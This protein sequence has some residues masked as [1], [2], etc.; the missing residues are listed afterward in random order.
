MGELENCGSTGFIPVNR[1][2]PTP[3]SDR[4]YDNCSKP[5]GV[6]AKKRKSAGKF[7]LSLGYFR[8]ITRM[9]TISQSM[10][11]WLW[12]YRSAAAIAAWSCR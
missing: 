4:R 12:I 2:S 9:T 7:H 1:Y 10:P 8:G 6:P 5:R 11:L 3:L